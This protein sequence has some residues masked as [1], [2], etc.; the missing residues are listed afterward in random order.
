M[1]ANLGELASDIEPH[2]QEILKTYGIKLEFFAISGMDIPEGDPNR[3][4]LEQ[5]YAKKQELHI[6]VMLV[7]Q[8]KTT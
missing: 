8:S 6:L 4:I 1:C 3:M 5:A 7:N 2:L